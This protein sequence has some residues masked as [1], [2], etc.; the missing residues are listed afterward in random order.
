MARR[1]RVIDRDRGWKRI[2]ANV[3]DAQGMFVK[4]GI[5]SS[6]GG[7]PKEDVDGSKSPD[8]TLAEVAWWNEFG[9]KHIPE[10]SFVRSTTDESRRKIASMKRRLARGMTKPRPTMTPAKSLEVLGQFMQ[11]RIVAKINALRTPPNAPSTIRRKKS[12]NPLVASKQMA[13]SIQYE[14]VMPA[15]RKVMA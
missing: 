3:A 8:T 9:T 2:K 14:V 12:S 11:G 4:I 15:G 5:T 6:V 10:R 7:N 13:Q 1:N